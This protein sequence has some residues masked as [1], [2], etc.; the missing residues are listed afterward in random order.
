MNHAESINIEHPNKVRQVAFGHEP[1]IFTD[2]YHEENNLVVWQRSLDKSL[3]ELA[4]AFVKAQ[5]SFQLSMTTSPESVL[6]S[7]SEVMADSTYQ[8]LAKDIAELVDM[9]CCLFDLSRA[10]LRLATLDKAM[11]PKF[12][13]DRVPCRLITT[14]QGLATQ[15]LAHEHVERS[16]LGASS[17]GLPDHESGLYQQ[18]SHIQQIHCGDVALLKGE[19]W[20]NNEQAGLVHRS[21]RLKAGEQR[22]LLTLDFA[23]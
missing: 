4:E 7:L 15:W 11:C 22:L 8:P 12:H 2:I 20:F 23:D 18:E 9:F 3:S 6:D 1:R 13:V 14:Y 21:P 19:N 16:K 5:P 17:K 10:G